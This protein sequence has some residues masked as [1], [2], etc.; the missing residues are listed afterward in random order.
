MSNSQSEDIQPA[1]P[2]EIEEYIFSLCLQDGL[3]SC[4]PLILV[5]KRVYQW[6]RPHFYKVAIFHDGKR[7]CG[8]PRFDSRLLKTHGPY[9]RHILFWGM[10]GIDISEETRGSHVQKHATYLSWCPNVVEVALWDFDTSYHENL[11]D[12]LLALPVKRLSFDITLFHNELTNS[13]ITKPIS[14]RSVTHLHLIGKEITLQVKKL[15]KYLPSI[16]HIA[17]NEARHLSA[18]GILDCWGNQLEILIWYINRSSSN[19]ESGVP[20]DPRIVII[21]QPRDY[22]EDW[23][24]ATEDGPGSVWRIAEAEVKGR[25]RCRVD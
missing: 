14:F 6:L 1:F 20:D 12:Q 8:R 18:Q 15:N 10:R 25:H 3:D 22:V 13:S 23:Y 17:I 2:P 7:Q 16:T 24:R 5:A 21:D 19:H 9:V 4:K 11:I